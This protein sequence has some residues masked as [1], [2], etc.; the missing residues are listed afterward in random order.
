M[1]Y[2]QVTSD[3]RRLVNRVLSPCFLLRASLRVTRVSSE[4]N[5]HTEQV[6]MSASII[7]NGLILF[8]N[9][10]YSYQ[11]TKILSDGII[12]SIG[13]SVN[14]KMHSKNAIY[15]FEESA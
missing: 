9:M 5:P 13:R 6:T 4:S 3:Y 7:I 15:F 10:F 11:L 1:F 8:I 14:S 2:Q 12:T